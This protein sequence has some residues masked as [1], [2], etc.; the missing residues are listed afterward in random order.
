MTQ[1]RKKLHAGTGKELG[2]T[3]RGIRDAL[4]CAGGGAR[5]KQ[6]PGLASGRPGGSE[7]QSGRNRSV[8]DLFRLMEE[9]GGGPTL[10]GG[11]PA[12]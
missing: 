3:H 2:D 12:V 8:D 4:G 5:G 11:G 9:A 10:P 6:S 1:G 7:P